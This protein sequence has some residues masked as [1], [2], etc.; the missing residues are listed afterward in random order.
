[1]AKVDCKDAT[2]K[3]LAYRFGIKR[4]PTFYLI[5]SGEAFKLLPFPAK[6]L[7]LHV[8]IEPDD[9]EAH[10]GVHGP[11]PPVVLPADV[12]PEPELPPP[13]TGPS[14]VVTLTDENFEHLVGGTTIAAHS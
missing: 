5:D 1:M 8:A 2:N 11:V 6:K 9:R 3:A 4:Y 7:L 13:H 10:V 12:I 14:D